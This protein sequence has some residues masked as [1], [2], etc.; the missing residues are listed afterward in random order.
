MTYPTLDDLDLAGKRVLVR[1]DLNVPVREGR[2]TDD[3]RLRAIVPTVHEILERG[4]RPVLL[5]H[6]G[7][8]KGRRVPE[9]SLEVVMPALLDTLGVPVQFASDCIGEEAEAA[10]GA[11]PPGEVLLLENTRFHPGEEANDPA[12][13]EALA[14]L[15]EVY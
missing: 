15:G 11:L 13:A 4:G 8:P 1:V 5:A 7:R 12:F 9:M 10:A 6:F 3:T 2:V 14:R